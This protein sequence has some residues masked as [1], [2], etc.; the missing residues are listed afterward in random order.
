MLK[1]TGNPFK[2]F[3]FSKLPATCNLQPATCNLQLA[4]CNLQPATCNLQP[5]TCNLQPATCDLQPATCNLQPATCNLQLATCNLQPATCNLQPATCNLQHSACLLMLVLL[6]L[7]CGCYYSFS[8]SGLTGVESVYVPVFA[9]TTIEYGLEND[10]TDAIIQAVN[11]ER[12]LKI[13][14]ATVSDA[15]LEGRILRVYD[16][17]LTYTGSEQVSEYKV[18]ITIHIK[19]TDLKKN[20]VL[21][22]EDFKAFGEYPYPETTDNNRQSGIKKALDKLAQ[23]IINKAVSGW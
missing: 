17:P 12:S 11:K 14:E 19:F 18:E 6:I 8:G 9:N 4:T 7:T 21:L 1:K 3:A 22:E 2:N 13:G 23:D 10:L 20:K 16:S 5:A 15:I